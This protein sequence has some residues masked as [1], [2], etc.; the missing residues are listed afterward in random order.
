MVSRIIQQILSLG[1]EYLSWKIKE[2][3]WLG[4]NKLG[5]VVVVFK[6]LKRSTSINLSFSMPKSQ[7]ASSYHSERTLFSFVLLSSEFEMLF[8]FLNLGYFPSPVSFLMS[9]I[10]FLSLTSVAN[11]AHSQFNL[12][13]VHWPWGSL[14]VV[15]TGRE[16]VGF[17]KEEATVGTNGCR[18][19]SGICLPWKMGRIRVYIMVKVLLR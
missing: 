19:D 5:H 11:M 1:R 16:D 17:L 9:Q 8:I 14:A 13:V 15:L 12:T 7:W 6:T 18:G 2:G 4:K 3:L 10:V